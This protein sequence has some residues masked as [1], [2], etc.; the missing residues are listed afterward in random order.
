MEG[1]FTRSKPE[2]KSIHTISFK[3]YFFK[4]AKY[5]IST[6]QKVR[7]ENMPNFGS[8]KLLVMGF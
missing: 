8:D 7:R 1:A 2:H 3:F 6:I 5:E 4:E